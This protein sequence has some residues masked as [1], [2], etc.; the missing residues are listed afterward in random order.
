MGGRRTI[1]VDRPLNIT[2]TNNTNTNANTSVDLSGSGANVACSMVGGRDAPLRSEKKSRMES[3][4]PAPAAAVP[5]DPSVA[6]GTRSNRPTAVS[7]DKLSGRSEAGVSGRRRI[8]EA[9]QRVRSREGAQAQTQAQ[10][11]A[12]GPEEWEV[13]ARRQVKKADSDSW[14]CVPLLLEALGAP[15]P[16]HSGFK[17]PETWRAFVERYRVILGDEGVSTADV[18]VKKGTYIEGNMQEYLMGLDRVSA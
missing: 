18:V 4:A 12:R 7:R 1:G 15:N 8:Y 3:G 11:C 17:R 5:L 13:Y 14:F 10:A 16:A 6:R 9:T 2:T